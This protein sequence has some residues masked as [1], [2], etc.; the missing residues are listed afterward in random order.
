[1]T[2]RSNFT[3]QRN[4]RLQYLQRLELLKHLHQD[5]IHL[6]QFRGHLRV[7]IARNLATTNVIN[8]KIF[9]TANSENYHLE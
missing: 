4:V 8:C 9:N 7:N 5:Y 3:P 1:M 6:H 2:P